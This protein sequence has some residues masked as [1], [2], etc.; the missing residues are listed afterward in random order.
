M[1]IVFLHRWMQVNNEYSRKYMKVELCTT[2]SFKKGCTVP[3]MVS[4]WLL[5]TDA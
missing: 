2:V 5:T 3:E 4:Y 1:E